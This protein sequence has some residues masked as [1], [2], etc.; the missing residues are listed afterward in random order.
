MRIAY[1]GPAPRPLGSVAGAATQLLV[2]LLDLGH[3]VDCYV[4]QNE[5]D[6][7]DALRDRIGFRL[8]SSRSGFR[9]GEWYSRTEL[10]KFVSGQALRALAEARLAREL[11][12]RHA[13]QPYDL[14][15]QFSHVEVFKLG[16]PGGPPIIVHPE[17]HTAGELRWLR[18]E[19]D[20]AR[21]C[22]PFYRRLAARMILGGRT[23]LQRRHVRIPVGFVFPSRA[24]QRSFC[25]D[26]PVDV[27]RTRV[28][29][30]PV[31]LETFRPHESRR[32]RK[33][34]V[35][36]VCISRISVRKGVE[37]VVELSHRLAD[38]AGTVTI[39]VVGDRT[40]WSDYRPLLVDLHPRVAQYVGGVSPDQ[41]PRILTEADV[42]VQASKYE[43]FGLTV[44]EAL[45]SGVPVVVTNQVGAAEDVSRECAR[46]VP[47]GDAEAL[48]QEVRSLVE[49][50]RA[51][52]KGRLAALARGEAERLFDPRCVAA[53]LADALQELVVM[54]G[55]N[56]RG[57]R[58]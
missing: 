36:I 33:G 42:L 18:V 38:L 12:S 29:P 48:E 2:G 28:V 51:G 37:A 39:E 44:G 54:N 14:V 56:R 46:V 26:Y 21:R 24:F 53:S 27:A 31:D 55:H 57:P 5:R 6:L 40:Q 3:S 25:S 11:V 32:P 35:K 17:T 22:E 16:R 1:L 34:P 45:A 4:T 23:A 47:V 15:Y 13:A 8:V 7:P 43:P 41:V 30:N 50:I 19:Q 9:Y 58:L 49:E 10:T 52:E 20:I